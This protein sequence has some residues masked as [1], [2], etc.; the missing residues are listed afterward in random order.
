MRKASLS[1]NYLTLP[2]ALKGFQ[3]SSILP[4]LYQTRTILLEP[5][6][7]RNFHAS[8]H[9]VKNETKS[10]RTFCSTPQRQD[11]TRQVRRHKKDPIVFVD[12]YHRKGPATPRHTQP[13][14]PSTVTKFEQAAFNRLIKDASEPTT[15]EPDAEDDLELD[16]LLSEYDPNIDLDSI[17]EEAIKMLREQEVEAANSAS[18]NILLGAVSSTKRAIDSLSSG[19]EPLLSARLFRRPLKLTDGTMLGSKVE[20][21]EERIR[22]EVACDD[23]RNLVI[24]MLDRAKTDVEIWNVLEQEVFS[25]INHLNQHV[26]M[27]RRTTRLRSAKGRKP[28]AKSK[29]VADVKLEK[30]D[31]DKQEVKSFKLTRTNAIPINNLLSILH[32]NYSDYCLHALRLFRRKHPLSSYGPLVFTTIKQSGPMSYV[33]G[34]ST[35]VYN[36]VLFLQWTQYSDLHGMAT[37]ID[38]MLNQGIE[39]NGVTMALIKGISKQ[40]RLGR[41]GFFGP[42]MSEWWKMPANVEGW[43]NMLQLSTRIMSDIAEKVATAVDQG[44]SE[45]RGLGPDKE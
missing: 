24:R 20:N 43:R 27:I 1:S 18:R 25:L 29:D 40:R 5:K 26:K 44:E 35:D 3:S 17:F 22:L 11:D 39:G 8:S 9:Q 30:D 6:T 4:I 14:R 32:R 37:T 19:G 10:R 36:E 7:P 21:E 38:E 12:P 23:H 31:L 13:A 16:E 2:F 45:E 34:V 15:P 33:L 42:V 41:R 28:E